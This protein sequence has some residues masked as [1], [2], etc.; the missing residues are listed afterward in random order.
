MARQVKRPEQGTS[1]AQP[2][3]GFS[4]PTGATNYNPQQLGTGTTSGGGTG[5]GSVKLTPKEEC[6]L[7]GGNWDDKT[8]TC[9]LYQP[10]PQTA[11]ANNQRSG[12]VAPA[13]GTIE[14]N[15]TPGAKGMVVLPDGRTLLGVNKDDIDKIA[16]GEARKVARPENS[17]PIGSAQNAALQEKRRA[18]AAGQIGQFEALPSLGETPIDWSQAFTAGVVKG[19]GSILRSVATAAGTGALV[20]GV[21]TGGVGAPIGAAVGAGI[22][23]VAG[24]YGAIVGNIEG[25]QRGE[26][27]ATKDV[28]NVAKTDMRQL[29][30]LASQ[31]PANADIYVAAYNKRLSQVYQAYEKLKAET[32]GDLNKFID[33][34]T[35][36]LSD[37]ELFLAP[38]GTAEIYGAKLNNALVSG[39]PLS[40]TAEEINWA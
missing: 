21:P 2:G 8:Q 11:G 1:V 6:V 34:G 29:A 18:L 10:N 23:L 36:K 19:G 38:G 28:L 13:P 9:I 27:A 16:A 31:D 20:G 30:M 33:D 26:I 5:A 40:F 22:G 15:S 7:K 3:A 24:L 35:D 39:V 25:Q 12:S 17:A 14:S 37:F 4:I 32:S